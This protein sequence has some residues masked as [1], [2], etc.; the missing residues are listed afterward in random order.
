MVVWSLAL[1]PDVAKQDPVV[2]GAEYGA[3]F[4]AKSRRTASIQ[5][6]LHCLGLCHRE[7]ATFGWLY[8]SRR[9]RLMLSIIYQRGELFKNSKLAYSV[10]IIACSCLRLLQFGVLISKDC[11]SFCCT[12]VVMKNCNTP[13]SSVF[14]SYSMRSCIRISARSLLSKRMFICSVRAAFENSY[15]CGSCLFGECFRSG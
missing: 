12:A 7:S 4:L 8:S 11:V 14:L 2:Y 10:D 5:E 9:Y 15:I 1:C 3:V 13:Y 6:D